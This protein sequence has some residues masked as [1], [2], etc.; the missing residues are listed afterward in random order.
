MKHSIQICTI[1]LC[2]ALLMPEKSD[3]QFFPHND[4]TYT[5]VSTTNAFGRIQSYDG[6][7]GR[8]E[9]ADDKMIDRFYQLAGLNSNYVWNPNDDPD[10]NLIDTLYYATV[11]SVEYFRELVMDNSFRSNPPIDINIPTLVR[12]FKDEAFGLAQLGVTNVE[13]SPLEFEFSVLLRGKIWNVFGNET[14]EYDESTGR[15]YIFNSNGA[16]GIQALDRNPTGVSLI[17]FSDYDST[18]PLRDNARDFARW[19]EITKT[20][21]DSQVSVGPDGGWAFMN[22]GSTG[23]LTTG[24][25]YKVWVAFT[26]GADLDV[27]DMR[28]DAAI[29]KY[30]TIDTSIDDEQVNRPN[31]IELNQNYPNPF[32]PSTNI[33]FNLPEVADVN[34]S[35]FNVLGQKVATLV[36][37]NRA[38]GTHTAIFDASRL[39]SGMYIYRLTVNGQS[40]SRTMMLVK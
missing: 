15:I 20:T 4:T 12:M 25:S 8:F 19:D 26:H 10:I 37:G 18:D 16:V 29:D 28:L 30:N 32:N 2:L 13:D 11:D 6:E 22:F 7:D 40:L 23:E 24:E 3:A 31:K 34:L 39:N 33:S 17:D 21:F 36:D 38:A 1:L 14:Y 9:S 35:V 27:V 5:F